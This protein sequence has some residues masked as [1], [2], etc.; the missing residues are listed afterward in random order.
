MFTEHIDKGTS[1]MINVRVDVHVTNY[2]ILKT[3]NFLI[4]DDATVKPLQFQF[5]FRVH[6][7]KNSNNTVRIIELS[8]TVYFS[9]NIICSDFFK[10]L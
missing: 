3:W 6:S 4:I 10:L 1:G 9:I 7:S 2:D 5:N 8:S